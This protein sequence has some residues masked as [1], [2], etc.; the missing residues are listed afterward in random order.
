MTPIRRGDVWGTT[1]GVTVLV[2]SS[3]VYNEIADE[4]TV[5]V[6]PVFSRDPA[7]GFGVSIG[8]SQWAAPG[9]IT[10]LRKPDLGERQRRID[11]QSLTDLNT[12]LF[13]ILATP[14]APRPG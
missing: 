11:V 9:L 8:E 2:V 3:T 14:G 13:K 10:A 7:S 1:T 4:P 12:M 5:L 6:V